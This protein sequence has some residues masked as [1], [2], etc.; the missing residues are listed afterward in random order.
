MADGD[1]TFHSNVVNV[2]QKDRERP[3]TKWLIEHFKH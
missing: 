2:I 1:A 3:D